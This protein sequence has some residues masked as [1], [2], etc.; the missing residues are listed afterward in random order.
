MTPEPV[1]STVVAPTRGAVVTQM[2]VRSGLPSAVRGV[3]TAGF[4]AAAGCEGAWAKA[5]PAQNMPDTITAPPSIDAPS[6]R[7]HASAIG[8]L[9]GC[10]ARPGLSSRWCFRTTVIK[11]FP[12]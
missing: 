2:P 9:S 10:A 1:A 6:R 5:M 12:D 11:V 3:V 8:F 4:A 7:H